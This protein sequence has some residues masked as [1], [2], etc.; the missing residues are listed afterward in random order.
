[1]D[2]AC[3][4]LPAETCILDRDVSQLMRPGVLNSVEDQL[5]NV[6][7]PAPA[8]HLHSLVRLEIFFAIEEVLDLLRRDLGR[9]FKFRA[10][11]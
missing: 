4:S 9:F 10:L 2:C 11:V 6:L 5:V 1:M 3:A 7:G 8:Q